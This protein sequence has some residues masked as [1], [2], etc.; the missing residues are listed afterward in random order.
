MDRFSSARLPDIQKFLNPFFHTYLPLN[1]YYWLK[2]LL[3]QF[4]VFAGYMYVC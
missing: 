4:S 2:M 1:T 3:Q